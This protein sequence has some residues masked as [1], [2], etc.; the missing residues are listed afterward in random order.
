MKPERRRPVER[1]RADGPPEI[2]KADS[3][4]G[5]QDSPRAP[6][7][8][9]PRPPL[10]FDALKCPILAEHYFLNTPAEIHRAHLAE[11]D[12]QPLEQ[13]RGARAA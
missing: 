3:V 6:L 4:A 5:S 1:W 12:R 8:Q 7:D 9:A 2:S 10:G 13:G 11:R